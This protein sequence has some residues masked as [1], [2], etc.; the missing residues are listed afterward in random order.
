MIKESKEFQQ[1]SAETFPMEILVELIHH[2]QRW[3]SEVV[4]VQT[5]YQISKKALKIVD[6][7]FAM[8]LKKKYQEFRKEGKKD[9]I[10]NEPLLW[11]LKSKEA[12]ALRDTVGPKD[13]AVLFKFISHLH[14]TGQAALIQR[15]VKYKSTT[16]QLQEELEYASKKLQ[17]KNEK[18]KGIE[19]DLSKQEMHLYSLSKDVELDYLEQIAQEHNEALMELAEADY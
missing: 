2:D 18:H 6:G 15:I 10:F 14:R 4:S 5:R 7:G 3:L 8:K 9:A 13:E 1:K 12:Q 16:Q 17:K 11:S 19:L